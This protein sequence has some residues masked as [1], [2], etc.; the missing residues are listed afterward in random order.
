MKVSDLAKQLNVTSDYI[1][2][3]LKSLRFKSNDKDQELNDAVISVL[4]TYVNKGKE[5]DIKAPSRPV[6]SSTGAKEKEKPSK[7]QT[8]SAKSKKEQKE[9]VKKEI[10]KIIKGEKV[11]QVKPVIEPKKKEAKPVRPKTKLSQAPVI[12]LKPLA[13]KRKKLGPDTE[14]RSS[15][16]HPPSTTEDLSA[17]YRGEESPLRLAGSGTA[18]QEKQEAVGGEGVSTQP[19]QEIEIKLPITVGDLSFKIQQKSS[20]VLKELMKLGLFC[21]INQ[22]LNEEIVNKITSVFG[23]KL[24]TIKT[25]EEQI[26]EEHRQEQDDPESLKPRAPVVTFM[27]HVDHG[28]TSLLDKIRKSKIADLEH[29]GITQHILAYSL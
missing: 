21:H 10:K 6:K 17:G 18:L 2:K 13:R 5:I 1:L 27:G 28:K 11:V 9:P 19:L 25:Q 8:P 16:G 29:G 14:S 4:K 15:F 22:N 7:K 26:I 3:M 23:Y 24:A 12:T 20:A